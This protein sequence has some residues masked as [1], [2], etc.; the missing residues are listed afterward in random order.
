MFD[1][2][3]FNR[4]TI[5]EKDYS[6][7]QY[8]LFQAHNS[9]TV[10]IYNTKKKYIFD[11]TFVENGT[12]VDHNQND[13]NDILSANNSRSTCNSSIP[14]TIHGVNKTIYPPNLFDNL[15]T[16]T[17]GVSTDRIDSTIT[18][19]HILNS[20]IPQILYPPLT[21][22]L[23]CYNHSGVNNDINNHHNNNF[24]EKNKNKND[25]NKDNK[26]PTKKV[27]NNQY[28]NH[29]SESDNLWNNNEI[30]KHLKSSYWDEK[31]KF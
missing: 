19:S 27:F 30:L 23:S 15:E 16:R 24:H 31:W 22:C 17:Y 20:S 21:S 18:C 10:S 9:A 3:E 6:L 13:G 14:H 5:R 11:S 12:N 2:C 4:C 26:L 7:L 25:D 1:T 29:K 28:I 8:W